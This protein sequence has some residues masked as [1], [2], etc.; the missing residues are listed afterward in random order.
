M[1][2]AKGDGRLAFDA[3]KLTLSD[4]LDR[5][6]TDAVKNSVKPITFEQYQ[7][8]VLVHISPALGHLKLGKLTPGHPQGLYQQ[9]LDAGMAPSSVRYM[10]AVLHGALK[11]AHKWRLVPEN[12]AAATTPPKPQS[13]EIGPLDAEEVKT[14][15]EAARGERLEALFGVAVTGGLRIGELRGLKWENIGLERGVMRVARTLS[16]AKSGPRFTTPKNGKG[17]SIKLT[18]RA[19]EALKSHRKRQNEERPQMGTLWENHGLVFPSTTGRPLSRNSVD[20]RSFKSLLRR[21]GLR[22]TTRLHDL[23]HTCATLLLGQGVHPKYVQELLGHASITIT[24]NR[25]RHW[26]PAMGDRAA[27]AMEDALA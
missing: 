12:V 26:I 11:Q 4:Y 19:V 24:L 27:R 13:K 8:Q 20:R 25:Y 22:S 1:A 2:V 5:W 6:L 15:L 18:G 7:R 21:V 16:E 10:H 14:L 3:D 23:R 17:R 9:K